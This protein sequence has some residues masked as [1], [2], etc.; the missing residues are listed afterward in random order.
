L[1]VLVTHIDAPQLRELDINF[2]N[3]LVFV[4]AQ[5]TRFIS[6]TLTFEAFYEATVA[7]EDST[8]SVELTSA[9][10]ELN[11]SLSV[12]VYCEELDWQLSFLEQVCTPFLPSLSTLQDLYMMSDRWPQDW[13]DNIDYEQWLELLH[14]FS[15][16]KNLYLSE[17]LAPC[18]V[19]ALK[20]LI[21]G[22][23]AFSNL[24][25]IFVEELQE[26]GPVEEGIGKFVAARQVTSHPIT[27]SRWDRGSN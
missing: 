23:T 24:Q 9:Y 13:K 3:D 8:A 15:A 14:S 20:D 21:G 25:N 18:V 7:F 6:H 11:A 22:R 2:F 12:S 10:T 26:S 16:V 17:E 19:P 1:E 5:L 4:T 27:V